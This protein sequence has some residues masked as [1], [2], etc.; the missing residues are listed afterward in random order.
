MQHALLIIVVHLTLF[1]LWQ[2]IAGAQAD[3][4][5]EQMLSDLLGKTDPL[6][7]DWEAESFQSGAS[8][9]LY[10]LLDVVS[11]KG[12]ELG[13][14]DH[15]LDA[16]PSISVLRPQQL[17]EQTLPGSLQVRRLTTAP[18]GR[19]DSARQAF[20]NLFAPF[21]GCSGIHFKLKIT[22]VQLQGELKPRTEVRYEANATCSDYLVQQVA[23]WDVTFKGVT[24]EPLI[25]RIQLK[26]FE[27][28]VRPGP[29][30]VDR[31]DAVLPLDASLRQQLASG[32]EYWHGRL[33]AVGEWN[34]MGH[35]GIAIGDYD[36][37][38]REDVYVAMG[39][40]LPNKL[41]VHK[42]DGTVE[43]VADEAGVAWLDD[44][45][46]VVFADMDNDGDQDLLCAIG[47]NI[48]LCKNDGRGKFKQ[49]VSMRAATPAPFYSLSVADYD[50][51]GDLDIYG[52]RYVKLRYGE[53]VPMPFHDANNGPSNHLM[54][55]DGG[56][57]FVDVTEHVGLGAN[58]ARFSLIG[59]WGDYDADGDP[60][61]Y[62]T[63]D[64]GRNNLYRNDN[65]M[66]HDVAAEVGAED[67]AAGMGA[68]WGDYDLDGDLDLYVTNMF[69]SAGNRIAYQPRFKQHDSDE[70]RHEIQRH[71]LGNTLLANQGDGTFRDVSDQAGVR[72]G[73]WG[74]GSKFIDVNNDGF[75]DLVV[76]NGF[77][78]G[79]H[80]DDL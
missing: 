48:V 73:R 46:G 79:R 15:I 69:S 27:E 75:D 44:T 71:A 18:P 24:A 1:A 7:D 29:L 41:F 61:L 47:Q 23:Y 6:N 33:D 49:F 36:G 55:N 30:F 50:L 70:T 19:A 11:E 56:D 59:A 54:R 14:C 65:G 77:L 58:N 31:T 17:N 68:A 52:A 10:R 32:G 80:K 43:D 26:S 62:V 39:N 42:P 78:T 76:P 57:H 13:A 74:W 45:K 5:P 16:D 4:G 8:A 63:N 35:S 12:W 9:Q 28:C 38:G 60:D 25:S 2:P 72:M 53:S 40:G 21:S 51:D 34:L 20:A 22:G 67:Q 64:F 3:A 37:D 66:F